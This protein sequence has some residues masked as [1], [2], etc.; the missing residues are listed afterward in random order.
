MEPQNGPFQPQNGRGGISFCFLEEGK[1]RENKPA[2]IHRVTR[3]RVRIGQISLP[4]TLNLLF[5]EKGGRGAA[6]GDRRA[7]G[8]AAGRVAPCPSAIRGRDM[9][10]SLNSLKGGYIGD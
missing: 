5:H 6:I 9:S 10:Y 2:Q 8:G 7:S 1:N 4:Q 3:I